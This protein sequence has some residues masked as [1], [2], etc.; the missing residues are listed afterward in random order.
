MDMEQTFFNEPDRSEKFISKIEKSPISQLDSHF[1]WISIRL[2]IKENLKHHIVSNNSLASFAN[3]EISTD[4]E[5]D[6]KLITLKSKKKSKGAI[7][8]IKLTN[9]K[10]GKLIVTGQDEM[11]ELQIKKLGYDKKLSSRISQLLKAMDNT[12][13]PLVRPLPERKGNRIAARA[14][15]GLIILPV[16]NPVI[17]SISQP[18][19]TTEIK[20]KKEE[21]K[22]SNIATLN[23]EKLLPRLGLSSRA[24]TYRYRGK[25]IVLYNKQELRDILKNDFQMNVS[26]SD[27]ISKNALKIAKRYGLTNKQINNI[28]QAFKKGNGDEILDDFLN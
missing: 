16:Y 20:R 27:P 25:T 24:K 15:V 26:A 6:I 10:G 1:N 14:K 8:V 19:V 11:T 4:L 13:Q 7:G 18:A 22:F 2:A 3:K 17:A 9:F 12:V 28:K 5:R 23:L 21:I